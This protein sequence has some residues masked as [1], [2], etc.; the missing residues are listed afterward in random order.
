MREL[1][2]AMNLTQTEVKSYFRDG[3]RLSPIAER[4]IA[5]EI[6]RGQHPGDGLPYDAIDE[7]GKR[8][9]VRC[10]T[11]GGVYFCPSS[12]VGSGRTFEE[13]GFLNKLDIVE[14]FIICDAV[15]FPVV[16][17]WIIKSGAI[18]TLWRSGALGKNSSISRKKFFVIFGK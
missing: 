10:M 11:K 9:E 1:A 7:S 15:Q 14:G 2:N 8:W 17:L 16:P 13:A 4:R 6:L 5:R 18:R 12:M 3:R